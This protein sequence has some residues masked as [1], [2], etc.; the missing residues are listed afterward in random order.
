MNW[1]F[2]IAGMLLFI[3]GLLH[4]LL[5]ERLVFRR[6]RAD[7]FIPTQGGQLLR[8]PHVRILWATWHM[9]TVMGWCIALMLF[10]MALPTSR[11]QAPAIV[12][13]TVICTMLVSALLV[14]VGTKGRHPGWVGLLVVG[15]LAIVGQY[16]AR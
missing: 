12:V 4:S 16:A 15:V 9:A 3:V 6:L 8:E 14:L 10:W 2:A 11:H 7:T 1:Y 5:G 13:Q